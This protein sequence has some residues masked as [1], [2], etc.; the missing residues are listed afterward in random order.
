MSDEIKR[1]LARGDI[2]ALE[3]IYDE[4]SK[5]LYKF[6][7]VR[8]PEDAEDILQKTFLKIAKKKT[9]LAKVKNLR[10]YLVTVA[11]NELRDLM[12]KRKKSEHKLDLY[13]QSIDHVS[14]EKDFSKLHESLKALPADQ[15][16]LISLKVFAGL[17]FNEISE[18]LSISQN[19]AASRY[20]YA[21]NKLKELFKR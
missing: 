2:K 17:K 6:I 13:M 11:L 12:R 15:Q 9:S 14:S 16:E 3:L 8:S 18:V 4:Y 5:E 20:R 10:A 21:L 1:L 19:T 7:Y